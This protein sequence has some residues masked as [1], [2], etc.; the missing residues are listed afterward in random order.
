[1]FSNLKYF[2]YKLSLNFEHHVKKRKSMWKIK[3]YKNYFKDPNFKSN[4]CERK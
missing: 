2:L 1:M 4:Y 3:A